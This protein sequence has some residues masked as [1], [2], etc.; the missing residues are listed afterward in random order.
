MSGIRGLQGVLF[1][2]LRQDS[3]PGW[4]RVQGTTLDVAKVAHVEYSSRLFRIWNRKHP[5]TLHITY[6]EP[7][8]ELSVAPTFGASAGATL[9]NNVELTSFIS[10][11]YK[12]E[13]DCKEEISEILRKQA[14]LDNYIQRLSDKITK[15]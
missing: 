9:Y 4:S 6:A 14:L 2:I 11:R 12:C 3:V 1:H 8:Q 13:Q 7:R 10:R 5:Y 15:V